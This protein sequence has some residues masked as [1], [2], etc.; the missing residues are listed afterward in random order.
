MSSIV[1]PTPF[2]KFGFLSLTSGYVGDKVRPFFATRPGASG[3]LSLKPGEPPSRFIAWSLPN[4]GPYNPSPLV[5]G[6]HLYVL[7]DFGFLSC[8]EARTGKVIYDKQRVQPDAATAFTALPWGSN[9]NIFALS[10][11]GDTFDFHAGPEQQTA[12]QELTR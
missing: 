5:Y 4:A 10:E 9:G 1:I 12:A 7:F 6:D 11:D 2:S 3:D 8:L